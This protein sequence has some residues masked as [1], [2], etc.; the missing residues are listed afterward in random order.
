MKLNKKQ[1]RTATIASMAALLAVVLGM[2]GQTFAKY[3]TTMPA[4]TQ[5]ATVAKWGFVITSNI[6]N[7]FGKTYGN[8][9]TDK[10]VEVNT[11]DEGTVVKAASNTLAPGTKGEMTF[12]FTGSAEVLAKAE[13]TATG[14]NIVLVD[15]VANPLDGTGYYYPIQW[16]LKDNGTPVDFT[17]ASTSVDPLVDICEYFNSLSS[18]KIEVGTTYNHHFVLSWQWPF[19]GNDVKDTALGMYAND[20]TLDNTKYAS[21]AVNFS[22]TLN[23]TIEQIQA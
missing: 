19:E 1:K 16:T 2:G 15:K 5:Q 4:A 21:A 23:A 17:S 14:T 11:N 13:I 6:D 9:V 7:M 22:F 3:I 18:A 20:G 12:D 8:V 10:Y